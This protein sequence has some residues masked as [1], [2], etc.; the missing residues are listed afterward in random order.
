MTVGSGGTLQLAIDAGINLPKLLVDVTIN[1]YDESQG[2][3]RIE[4]IPRGYQQSPPHPMPITTASQ[5]AGRPE[6]KNR[7]LVVFMKVWGMAC[8]TRHNPSMIWGA[9]V[10]VLKV[11]QS[12]ENMKGTAEL[13]CSAG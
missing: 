10:N 9:M 4:V 11:L 3:H 5:V 6:G 1:K 12:S 2:S 13:I 7:C 8:I